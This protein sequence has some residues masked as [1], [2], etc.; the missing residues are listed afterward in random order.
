MGGCGAGEGTPKVEGRNGT[1]RVLVEAEHNRAGKH[2]F[3]D[4][5]GYLAVAQGAFCSG[6]PVPLT[7]LLVK[8]KA[9]TDRTSCRGGICCHTSADGGGHPPAHP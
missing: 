2:D 5:L 1:E 8:L 7:K 9:R 6:L 4:L 3:P